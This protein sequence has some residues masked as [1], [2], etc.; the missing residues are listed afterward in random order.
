MPKHTTL[1]HTLLYH[2]YHTIYDSPYYD[3]LYCKDPYVYVVFW[4]TIIPKGPKSS[5]SASIS[6]KRRKLKGIS[7]M[8]SSTCFHSSL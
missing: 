3:P 5:G 8:A 7:S 2:L 1:Y 4:A 6:W